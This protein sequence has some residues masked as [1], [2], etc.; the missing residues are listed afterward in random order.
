MHTIWGLCEKDQGKHQSLLNHLNI[1]FFDNT[2]DMRLYEKYN[3]FDE[4]SVFRDNLYYS[5]NPEDEFKVP[6][7]YKESKSSSYLQG[8]FPPDDLPFSAL[9][10]SEGNRWA[11]PLFLE[12]GAHDYQLA[13]ESPA[14][15]MGI[16]Q[17]RLDNFGIQPDSRPSYL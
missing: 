6:W 4:R 17:I 9:P 3:F 10:P 1:Y 8:M 13:S 2:E 11:D 16:Q 12:P 14:L 7:V 15:E 5:L